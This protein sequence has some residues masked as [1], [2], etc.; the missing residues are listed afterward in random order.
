[1]ENVVETNRST[2]LAKGNT[3]I[4]TVEHVLATFAG[5]GIDNAIV[6]L[7]ANEPP[8]ARRQRAR[9]LQDG[10]GGGIV[11][12][13]ERRE[14]YTVTAPIELEMGETVMTLF[15]DEA[16]KISCTSA[17]KQGRFTQFYS[18]EVSPK[19]W[20]RDLA[21]ARTFCF[22]RGDRVP[23]QER[24]DQRRQP[25]ERRG[26][27][28]RRGADDRAAALSGRIRPA[29]DAGHRG[30]PVAAGPAAARAPDCG[31]AQPRGQL[32]AGPAD[33]GANAQA[34]GG[35]PGLRPAAVRTAK[36]RRAG[37]NAAETRGPGWGHG[38]PGRDASCCRT[39]IR[40]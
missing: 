35:R 23:D 19:T 11:P 2:T 6:E 18:L 15:P 13:D 26:D 22:L 40:S 14:P 9:V 12:Q 24:P 16:F 4:H 29:Q 33:R 27:S 31:Q 17:D 5:Y 10:P 38:H 28:R 1:M 36:P 37:R 32:R 25:G 39:A 3:R 30:G 20:E 34:A 21:H 7:D 8:I